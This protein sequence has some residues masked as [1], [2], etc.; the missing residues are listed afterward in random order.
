MDHPTFTGPVNLG[1]PGEVSVR[2][3]AAEVIALAGSSSSIA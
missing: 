1:N 3:L 2:Q